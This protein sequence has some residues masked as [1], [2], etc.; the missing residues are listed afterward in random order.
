M[1]TPVAFL[2][3]TFTLLGVSPIVTGITVAGLGL[4]I[5]SVTLGP[6]SALASTAN[7]LRASIHGMADTTCSYKVF[8]LI[9]ALCML[10]TPCPFS[11]T[12]ASP[13]DGT[14]LVTRGGGGGTAIFRFSRRGRL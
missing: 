10:R 8:S 2:V 13:H 7:R 9:R 12:R 11:S 5:P 3:R 1:S 6:H 4:N 14:V